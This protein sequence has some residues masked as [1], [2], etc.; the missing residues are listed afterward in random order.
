MAK[1]KKVAGMLAAATLMSMS[2]QPATAAGKA[3][4][5][6]F[7]AIDGDPMPLSEF[8]GKAVLVVNTASLCGFTGQYAGLQELY[9]SR[10][11]KGLVVIGVPSNNFGNQEPGTEEE[12]AEFCEARYQ[13]TFPM[14]EKVDVVGDNAHPFYRWISAELGER[15]APRWNFYKYLISPE[16]AVVGSWPSTTKPTAKTITAEVDKLL[17]GQ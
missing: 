16:G 2:P 13:V 15:R 12:I 8:K 9:Q 7:T 5:F 6:E 17:A 4:D 10:A 11:D 1:L 3:F 14:T